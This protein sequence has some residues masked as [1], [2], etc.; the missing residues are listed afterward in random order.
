MDAARAVGRQ[1]RI[2]GAGDRES[3]AREDLFVRWSEPADL[4][5]TRLMLAWGDADHA[6]IIETNERFD[7]HLRESGIP[8][9]TLVFAGR[10][11]WKAWRPVLEEVLS[12]Q[13]EQ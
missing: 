13:L 6:Q 1:R 8:H 3:I 10:H 4:G 9:R 5:G 11:D 12:I 2:W 7:R